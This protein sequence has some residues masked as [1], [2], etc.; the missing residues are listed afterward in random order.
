M[1]AYYV[2]T[3]IEKESSNLGM[4][5]I[6]LLEALSYFFSILTAFPCYYFHKYTSFGHHFA[7]QFATVSFALTG[8]LILCFS[9]KQLAQWQNIIPL[10]CLYGI[11]RG[12][13]EGICRA[14]YA[15]LFHG[16][17]LGPA[18]ATQTLLIGFSG[19][20]CFLLYGYISRI[21]IAGVTVVNGLIALLSY[22]MM[23]SQHNHNDPIPWNQL[24]LFR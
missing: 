17:A 21:A 4:L 16:E 24:R 8:I 23:I 22:Q 15:D 20:V 12:V 2:N 9:N 14:V 3:K 1:F 18:Y 11:G 6:G 19:G 5:Y 10:R 7:I 13:I